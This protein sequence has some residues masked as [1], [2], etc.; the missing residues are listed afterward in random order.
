MLWLTCIF[1]S[2]VNNEIVN[3]LSLNVWFAFSS[4]RGASN[5]PKIKL[6]CDANDA[7]YFIILFYFISLIP[8]ASW[9]APLSLQAL[10][11]ILF[12]QN[13]ISFKCSSFLFKFSSCKFRFTSLEV[14]TKETMNKMRLN[15]TITCVN[16]VKA[17]RLQVILNEGTNFSPENWKS[18]RGN[19]ILPSLSLNR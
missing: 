5:Q 1:F 14:I 12:E 8:I 9:Y 18:I 16:P 4:V 15:L 7:Y 17:Q 3:H 19:R 6:L 10:S 13:C 2:Y 11:S